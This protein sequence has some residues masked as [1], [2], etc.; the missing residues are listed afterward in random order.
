MES[1]NTIHTYFTRSKG[2]IHTQ[3]Q[4]YTPPIKTVNLQNNHSENTRKYK[5]KNPKKNLHNL[6]TSVLVKSM[7]N[8][9][10]SDSDDDSDSDFS[11]SDTNTKDIMG[12]PKELDYVSDE[13]EYISNISE[14]DRHAIFEK[15]KTIINYNKQLIPQ[16]FKIINSSLPLNVKSN[17]INRIDYFNTLDPSESEYHKIYNWLNNL[18]Q[19]PFDNYYT[20]KITINDSKTDIINYLKTIKNNLDDCVFGHNN[21]KEQ[22]LQFMAQQVSNPNSKGGCIAIQGPPG[23]GKTT[24][25]KHGICNAIDRPFG[26]IPLGGLHSS[27]FL[28]GHDYTYEGS[29]CGRILE[30]L[31][32]SQC[33]NPVIYFDELDK[34]SES[35]KGNEIENLL[36]HLTDFTQNNSFID[37]YFSGIEFD[38]SR[39]LFIFS[40]NDESKINPVLLDRMY[41]INTDGFNSKSKI[42]IATNYLLPSICSE[43]G[44]NLKDIIIKEETLLNIITNLTGDEKGVRNLKRCLETIVSKLNVL[45]LIHSDNKVCDINEECVDYVVNDIMEKIVDEVLSFQSSSDTLIDCTIKNFKLPIIIDETN[46]E[47]FIPKQKKN[48]MCTMYL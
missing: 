14:V 6:L 41:K 5:I 20:S 28:I 17:I 22:I 15:E 45:K 8:I 35:S 24:L 39:V 44:F 3:E 30:V 33:M 42:N 9:H 26:F 4:A 47:K 13:E 40:Y 16:R 38:L 12:I 32:E 36:C 23:N 25:V 37:K 48:N 46:I 27:D 7:F 2:S 11:D 29:K 43:V 10:S 31:Q 18:K 1:E 19:I 21:A 34:L